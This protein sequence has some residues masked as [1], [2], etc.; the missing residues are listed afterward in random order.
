MLRERL[1]SLK[2]EEQRKIEHENR[3]KST[4]AWMDLKTSDWK[5]DNLGSSSRGKTWW[6]NGIRAI[7][8]F[9]Q[10]GEEWIKGR[11]MSENWRTKQKLKKKRKVD[12]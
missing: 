2:T 9:E 8:S 4:K 7:R 1:K 11:I 5:K 3:S 6:N 12:K 10:P